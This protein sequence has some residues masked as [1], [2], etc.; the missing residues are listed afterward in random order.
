MGGNW[1]LNP[2]TVSGAEDLAN[3]LAKSIGTVATVDS[4]IFPPF[5]LIPTVRT[6]IAQSKIAV[7][8]S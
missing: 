5:P 1:K 7:R 6:Q 4:I 2:T 3:G 8:V